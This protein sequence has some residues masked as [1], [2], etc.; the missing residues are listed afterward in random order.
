MPGRLKALSAA[1]CLATGIAAPLASARPAQRDARLPE[2]MTSIQAVESTTGLVLHSSYGKAQVE[3]SR[4][5]QTLRLRAGE[6]LTTIAESGSGWIVGGVKR[7]EDGSSLVLMADRPGYP[8]RF[9]ALPRPK[10][11]QLRP[12]LL[13]SNGDFRG[14]AWLEGE[15]HRA[16]AVRF[17][18]WTGLDWTRPT[19]V[20]GPGPGSQTGLSGV[21]LRDGGL[22]LTW[23]RFDG[24]DDEI[25]WSWRRGSSWS[26]P[27][28]LGANNRIPDVTPALAATQRGANLVWARLENGEYRLLTREFDAGNWSSERAI[29]GPGSVFPS[30]VRIQEGLFVLY[31]T[32]RRKGWAVEE[33]D[34]GLEAARRAEI[35]EASRSRPI[36][37]SHSRHGPLLEWKQSGRSVKPRWSYRQP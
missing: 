8:N 4:G 32:A 19:T 35:A 24:S 23:S 27:S 15:N 26:R 11:L 12:V 37:K 21:A 33:L 22:L 9:P 10:P 28:R 18:E 3:T 6:Q 25:H 16:M 7:D 17:A 1:L 13:V 20:A 30:L 5:F 2:R 31:R 14:V 36:L 29:G 34:N